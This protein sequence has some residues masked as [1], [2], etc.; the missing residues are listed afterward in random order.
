MKILNAPTVNFEATL[1]Q[2]QAYAGRYEVRK[3]ALYYPAQKGFTEIYRLKTQGIAASEIVIQPV[4][5]LS[6]TL[7]DH[8]PVA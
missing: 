1:Y 5:V 8:Q 6:A 2:M 4:D 7:H 3:L